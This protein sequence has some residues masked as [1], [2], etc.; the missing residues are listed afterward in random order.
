MALVFRRICY[1]LRFIPF[2]HHHLCR[3]DL[4][5]PHR[6]PG[7]SAIAW[8]QDSPLDRHRSSGSPHNLH[9]ATIRRPAF[10][11]LHQDTNLYC[12]CLFWTHLCL[13]GRNFR[14]SKLLFVDPDKSKIS[15]YPH[16][17]YCHYFL[18]RQLPLVMDSVISKSHSFGLLP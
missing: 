14:E 12:V 7:I 10:Y 3:R 8:R 18:L 15:R 2:G 4:V 1:T 5:Q 9:T 16:R 11:D 17:L 6:R 13:G